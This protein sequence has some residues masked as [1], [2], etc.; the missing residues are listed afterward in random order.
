MCPVTSNAEKKNGQRLHIRLHPEKD[1]DIITHLNKQKH[2]S[3]YIKKMV[4][5]QIWKEENGVKFVALSQTEQQP[6]VSSPMSTS[7]VLHEKP[8][9]E[10]DEEFDVPEAIVEDSACDLFE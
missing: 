8:T 5:E 10:V 3:D 7:G 2:K 4:R 9:I 1:A 6:I